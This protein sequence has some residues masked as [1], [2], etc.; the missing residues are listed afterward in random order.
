MEVTGD[1][2]AQMGADEAGYGAV[3]VSDLLE[4]VKAEDLR[5]YIALVAYVKGADVGPALRDSGFDLSDATARQVLH[6]AKKRVRSI[7]Q[8]EG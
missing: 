4:R 7:F 3:H 1:P 2:A 6:R 5:S 8:G